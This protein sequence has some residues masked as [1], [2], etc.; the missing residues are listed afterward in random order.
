MESSKSSNEGYGKFKIAYITKNQNYI[1]LLENA[2]QCLRDI[3]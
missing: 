3:G 1:N 2:K